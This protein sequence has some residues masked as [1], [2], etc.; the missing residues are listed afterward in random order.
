MVCDFDNIFS[1][2]GQVARQTLLVR[3]QLHNIIY[4]IRGDEEFRNF[5]NL[6]RQS[7]KEWRCLL[8]ID[9]V[10]LLL[11][12]IRLGIWSVLQI[13]FGESGIYDRICI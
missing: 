1:V 8:S 10:P 5:R 4:Y 7:G 13:D 3:I 6:I 11:F 2:S 12:S 9:A